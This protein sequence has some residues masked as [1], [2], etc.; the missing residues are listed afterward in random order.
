MV[1]KVRY[2]N[3]GQISSRFFMNLAAWV[4]FPPFLAK[5]RAK[6]SIFVVTSTFWE[7]QQVSSTRSSWVAISNRISVSALLY[8]FTIVRLPADWATKRAGQ[9][10]W[11]QVAGVRIL[12]VFWDFFGL[13]IFAKH[14]TKMA[15]YYQSF[16]GQGDSTRQWVKKFVLQKSPIFSWTIIF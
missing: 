11:Q 15:T 13:K 14:G 1:F 6:N 4:N 2:N 12:R 7:Q 16:K 9:R 5:T 10:R 8:A 3:F